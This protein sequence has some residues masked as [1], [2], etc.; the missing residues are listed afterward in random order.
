[1]PITTCDHCGGDYRWSWSEAF[2]K[3][4]FGDGDGQ[5]MTDDVCDVLIRAGFETR[6]LIWG[7]HNVVITSIVCPERG[8][9]MPDDASDMTVGYDDPRWY[10]PDDII[11]LLD[12]ELA[13]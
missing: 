10:L 13:D 5:V 8:E 3:F 4:G 7:C 12:R 6:Q 2:D 9:L 1:M 11:A